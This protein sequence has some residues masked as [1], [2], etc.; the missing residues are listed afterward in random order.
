MIMN[1]WQHVIWQDNQEEIM[2]RKLILLFIYIFFTTLTA[3]SLF[4]SETDSV[5]DLL[6]R[7]S[8]VPGWEKVDSSVYFKGKKVKMYD[9][10]YKD[11]GIEK[12]ASCIYHSIDNHD[13]KI[14][15]EVIK[16]GSVLNAYGFFSI[17]RGPG[18]FEVS[19]KNEFDNNSVSIIQIGEY[20]IYSTTD[21]SDLLMKKDLKTFANIPLQY[22]G[23]NY[24]KEKL[25]E[26]SGLLKGIDGYGILYSIRNYFKFPLLRRV[27]FTNWSWNNQM[28][29]VF[30][31]EEDSFY[32]AY[33][34][35]K[36]ITG[37]NSYIMISSDNTYTAFK[38]ETD[39]K[40]SFISLDDKYIFG[41]W[42]VGDFK[43][44]KK[45]LG[46]IKTRIGDYKKRI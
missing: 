15:L 14:K 17:K 25:P 10:E 45:I 26:I 43:E 42:S 21:Q 44:G 46:E 20:A 22:L 3:C 31:S 7:D 33:E 28:I 39:D 29:D 30:L 36:K 6:P 41:C 2:K 34:L 12:L 5:I 40:Y 23:Q 1:I 8:D 4:Q 9:R 16:F 32:D 11:I 38:K 24:I 35:F 19:D 13:I 27:Y 37:E 18:I